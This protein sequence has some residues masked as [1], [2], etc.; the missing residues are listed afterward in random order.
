[1]KGY[2][3]LGSIGIELECGVPRTKR[4]AFIAWAREKYGR[5]FQVND[6][7]TAGGGGSDYV[8]SYEYNLWATDIKELKEYLEKAYDT[9]GVKT[10]SD[11]GFHFHVKPN[12]NKLEY[13][14]VKADIFHKGYQDE[15]LNEYKE[16]FRG[17]QRYLDRLTSRWAN[18]I[19]NKENAR[20]QLSGG[21]DRYTAIN[22]KS[23]SEAQGTI[24]FRILPN[25]N[26]GTEAK[27]SLT[28]MAKTINNLFKKMAIEEKKL[29]E[30]KIS[31]NH[32]YGG[33]TQQDISELERKGIKIKMG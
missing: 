14:L 33:F 6:D 1:M 24:E 22:L 2:P 12:I 19:Y 8:Q 5:R 16:H 32:D 7:G 23:A 20:M 25:Q 11:C 31:I 18:A 4:E 13:D 29:E 27:T 30:D 21:G 28:W 26:S 15:F 10:N 3:Y 9:Y 17:N